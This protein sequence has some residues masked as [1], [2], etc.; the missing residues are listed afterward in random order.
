MTAELG[1]TAKHRRTGLVEGMA[2]AKARSCEHVGDLGKECDS[3]MGLAREMGKEG[4]SLAA[5]DRKC[6]TK[7]CGLCPGVWEA[8]KPA[9]QRWRVVVEEA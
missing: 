6:Q 7:G 5:K 8:V 3:E 2:C 9:R 1:W 4:L